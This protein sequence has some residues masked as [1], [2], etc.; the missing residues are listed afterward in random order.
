E[1]P[2]GKVTWRMFDALGREVEGGSGTTDNALFRV[3]TTSCNKGIYIIEIS[4]SDWKV[5]K[6]VSVIK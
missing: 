4:T 2:R 3:T 5:R 1:T 6:S